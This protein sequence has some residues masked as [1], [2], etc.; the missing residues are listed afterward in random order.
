MG[1]PKREYFGIA[2]TREILRKC[3]KGLAGILTAQWS[4]LKDTRNEDRHV[5]STAYE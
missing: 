2:R 5:P 1:S 3:R 4:M